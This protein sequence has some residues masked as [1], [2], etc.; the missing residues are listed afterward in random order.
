MERVLVSLIL[1]GLAENRLW[2]AEAQLVV[3]KPRRLP[4]E[5]RCVVAFEPITNQNLLSD[6][7]F[8]NVRALIVVAQLQYWRLI[9]RSD[10]RTQLTTTAM[11]DYKKVQYLHSN[12]A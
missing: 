9:M 2:S 5:V 1:S 6:F 7:P 12:T 8:L 4:Q 10:G 11:P 3:L